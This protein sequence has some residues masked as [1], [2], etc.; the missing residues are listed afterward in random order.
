MNLQGRTL[1]QKCIALLIAISLLV[2]SLFVVDMGAFAAGEAIGTVSD[3]PLNVREGIGTVYKV[4]VKLNKGDQVI[5]LDVG[6]DEA[7]AAWYQIETS[8]G[9]KGWVSG[10]Y[11][12]VDADT[13]DFN[14]YLKLSGFPVSYHE[15]LKALHEKYPNWIFKPQHVDVTWDEMIAAQTKL[16]MSLTYS[17]DPTAWKSTQTGAY[18]WTTSQ[19]IQLDTGGWVAASKELVEYY[20]DPRNFL[21]EDS[22]FQF[23]KQ[24]YDAEALSEEEI[25]SVKAGVVNMVQ[26]SFLAG[27]CEEKDE[28]YGEFTT[29]V[30]ILMEAAKR[31]KVNPYVLV[32]MIFQ[33]QGKQ[34]TGNSISGTVKGYEGYYNFLNVNAWA[35][36]G[37][38]AVENGLIYAKERGW[39]TKTKSIIECAMYFGEGYISVGQDTIY[40]KKF[41]LVDS[42]FTH[43]YM[44]NIQGADLEGK[45]IAKAYLD[46][47]SQEAELEFKIPV[48]VNIPETACAK[49]VN[50]GNVCPNYMLKSL[51]VEGESLTPTFSMY[52]LEYNLIVAY[53]TASVTIKAEAQHTS[54]A[55][56]GIGKVDLS[57]GENKFDIKVTAESGAER[58]YTI[59][60]LREE[61]STEDPVVPEEPEEP[62]VIPNPVLSSDVYKVSEESSQITGVKNFPVSVAD[63]KNNLT[64]A[65]GSVTI[66]AADGTEMTG[67]IGTGTVVKLYDLEGTE[68]KSYT[69]IIYGDTNGDGTVNAKDLLAIQKN[70]I[71]VKALSGVYLTAADVTRDGK[72]NAKDLLLV[73]KNN[74]KVSTIEQ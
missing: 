70:N 28:T 14:L 44:T 33:E 39:N 58:T 50:N 21:T 66:L 24:S 4:L 37:N 12:T 45:H 60:I 10:T 32:S 20:V 23:L 30:D 61:T 63:F 57:V 53:E 55:I 35:H 19:W 71:Q 17:T 69:V 67:N 22:V 46:G 54:A 8:A 3:G 52:E 9:V 72:V 1:Q 40:L 48:Y 43:Q 31:S 36:S 16:G 6:Y 34:G 13:E 38:T 2:A 5:V 59:T 11:L 27:A 15:G 74:I 47:Q 62:V 64:V 73:Q 7:G 41:D 68:K 18:N 65:D 49:P 56:E 26:G 42:L 29:Y 51:E 25:E